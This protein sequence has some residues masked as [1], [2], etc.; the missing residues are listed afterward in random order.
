MS[1]ATL[2][3]NLYLLHELQEAAASVQYG[4]DEVPPATEI[5]AQMFA[6]QVNNFVD[7]ITK[8]VL[9]QYNRINKD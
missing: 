9:T 4:I 5:M 6:A 3:E 8:D 7:E 1:P 2:R